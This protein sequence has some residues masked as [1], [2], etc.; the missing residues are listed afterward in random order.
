MCGDTEQRWMKAGRQHSHAGDVH[1]GRVG[2]SLWCLVLGAWKMHL[3][4]VLMWM[5]RWKGVWYRDGLPLKPG[6]HLVPGSMWPHHS[7]P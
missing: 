1:L 4:G 5:G 6:P 7:V 3:P 2:R